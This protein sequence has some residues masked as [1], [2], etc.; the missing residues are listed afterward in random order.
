MIMYYF[1]KRKNTILEKSSYPLAFV[2]INL[3]EILNEEKTSRHTDIHSSI[4]ST[5]KKIEKA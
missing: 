3:S 4:I 5:S 1:I 2:G